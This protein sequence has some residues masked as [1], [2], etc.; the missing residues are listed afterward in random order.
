[1]SSPGSVTVWLGRLKAGGGRDEAVTRLWERYFTALVTR[2]RDHLRGRPAAAGGEDV[3]LSAFDAFVRAVAAGRFP[4]L[5]SRSD[6][7]QVL[8]VLT[9]RKAANAVRDEGRRKRGGGRV[10]ALSAA[11]GDSGGGPEPAGSEPDPAEV[12]ALADGLERLLAALDKEELRQVA[13]WAMAGHTNAEIAARLGRSV[14][15]AERKR[16]RVRDLWAEQGL[17]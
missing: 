6:L 1:M 13:V 16:R 10:V 7:W 12:V 5:D 17:A 15:T 9:A 4:R 3:A 14:A 11:A 8:L 2:A